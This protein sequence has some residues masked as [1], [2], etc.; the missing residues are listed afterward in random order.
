MNGINNDNNNNPQHGY[1]ISPDLHTPFGHNNFVFA[2]PAYFL[3]AFC[4]AGVFLHA[5]R[6]LFVASACFCMLITIFYAAPAR[7]RRL[8][9]MLVAAFAC[10]SVLFTAFPCL[11]MLFASFLQRWHVVAG[12]VQLSDSQV[13]RKV[14]R[15]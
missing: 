14:T 13:T 4:S 11:S 10:S 3:R 8:F 9:C 1:C 7:F 6:G 12:F 2:E 15:K 5:F